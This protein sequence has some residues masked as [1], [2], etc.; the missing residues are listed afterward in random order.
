M[1]VFRGVQGRNVQEKC[2]DAE[3]MHGDRGAVWRPTPTV[4]R[5]RSCGVVRRADR[6]RR[7]IR[8]SNLRASNNYTS[9]RFSRQLS[10][11]LFDQS[12]GRAWEPNRPS[13]DTTFPLGHLPL[14]SSPP[15][16]CLSWYPIRTRA[17]PDKSPQQMKSKQSLIDKYCIL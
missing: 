16:T 8:L 11:E 3:G 12:S 13:E 1:V 14:Q 9:E 6:P 10:P 5:P 2:P 7:T 17:V 4:D 15:N